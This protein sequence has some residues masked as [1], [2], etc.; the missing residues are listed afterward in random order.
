MLAA[1]GRPR[2]PG[3]RGPS[4]GEEARGLARDAVERERGA[5]TEGGRVDVRLVL[6]RRQAVEQQ[7]LREHVLGLERAVLLPNGAI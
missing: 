6:R 2:R 3:R 7:E 1:P 5:P 4:L